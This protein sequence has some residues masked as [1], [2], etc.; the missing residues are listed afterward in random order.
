M[1]RIMINTRE[2]IHAPKCG[3]YK[4]LPRKYIAAF[5]LS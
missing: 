5:T 1:T 2:I 4:Y 3:N